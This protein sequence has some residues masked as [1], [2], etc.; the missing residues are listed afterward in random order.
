MKQF[1]IILLLLFISC[2]KENSN[3][4]LQTAGKI[5]Q[6][7][8]SVDTFDKILV[9]KKVE[10][11]ISQGPQKVIIETGE[12]LI[13]DVLAE[14]IEGEL[15]L[16]NYN[17]CNFFRDY[18]LTKIHVTSPNITTLRNASEYQVSSKGILTFPS[19]F[20]KSVG[21]KRERLAVGDWHLNIV[22]SKVRIW[23]NGIANFY[24]TGKTDD[25][26]I[27]F[28]DG[29]TRFEGQNFEAQHIS[30]RQVSSNDILINPI[31]SLTGSIHSV[32]DV[33]SFNKPP[34]IDVDVQSDGKLIFK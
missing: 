13:S 7:E 15:I 3:D 30:V 25:L 21:E 23:G 4:C 33:I 28:S 9:N 5:I 32:G 11:I 16:S 6:K 17:T 26:N 34:I 1:T 2:D 20:L 14:V 31:E 27:S 29:D 24:I 22:N 18:G 8:I 10:L 19:I 12:N